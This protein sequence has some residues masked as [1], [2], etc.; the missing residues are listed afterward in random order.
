MIRVTYGQLKNP[1]F[2]KVTNRIYQSKMGFHQALRWSGIFKALQKELEIVNKEFEVLRK[3]HMEDSET[4]GVAKP[5]DGPKH[6]L[7][8]QEFLET[9]IDINLPRVSVN[10]LYNIELSPQ[11][12]GLLEG[13]IE[14]E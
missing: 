5:K 7:A 4:P 9:P 8:V 2:L 11:D 10:E 3:E 12:V 14:H 1:D 13:L 6:L